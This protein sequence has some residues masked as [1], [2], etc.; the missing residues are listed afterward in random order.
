MS[1]LTLKDP[2][3][4]TNKI[5]PSYTTDNIKDTKNVE[6]EVVLEIIEGLDYDE[7]LKLC[8]VDKRF[9]NI[10]KDE[11]IWLN[12][13]KSRYGNVDKI[14]NSWYETFKY[15]TTHKYAYLVTIEDELDESTSIRGLFY[16][17]SGAFN[18]IVNFIVENP[19][20]LA[21]PEDNS[22]SDAYI[23]FIDQNYSD[24]D[25]KLLNLYL[26]ELI[27]NY[28]SVIPHVKKNNVSVLFKDSITKFLKNVE[29]IL[30]STGKSTTIY[31]IY[32]ISDNITFKLETRVMNYDM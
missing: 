20:Y 30:K 19:L 23:K 29:K 11:S 8:Q 15:Y 22:I 9:S 2:S 4:I 17:K 32:D 3:I 28:G 14:C 5:I 27:S 12:M 21:L 13:V 24:N 10:C 16:N 6:N 7:I 26:S 25:S 1:T 18:F 31:D